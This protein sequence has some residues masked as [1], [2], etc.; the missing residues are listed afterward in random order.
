M[1]SSPV[2]VAANDDNQ[3]VGS[4]EQVKVGVKRKRASSS[5]SGAEEVEKSESKKQLLPNGAAKIAAPLAVQE[6]EE[7]ERV[8]I[9]DAGAQYGK[10]C[11]G[12]RVPRE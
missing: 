2:E 7:M 1:S 8:A 4:P 10:V 12:T 11:A 9:L 5:G 6:G 3:T